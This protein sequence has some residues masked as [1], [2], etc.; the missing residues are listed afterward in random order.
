MSYVNR[1]LIHQINQSARLIAK[2]AN[3]QLEPF[4]LYSS[5]WSVLYCLR[6]IGPMTQKR[7]GP[8]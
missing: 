5:Q 8:I 7:F 1:H 2:K 4:G 3:E 6:T